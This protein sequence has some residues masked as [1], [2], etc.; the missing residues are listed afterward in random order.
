MMTAEPESRRTRVVDAVMGVLPSSLVRWAVARGAPVARVSGRTAVGSTALARALAALAQP[1]KRLWSRSGTVGLDDIADRV[2]RDPEEVRR[3]AAAGLLGDPDEPHAGRWQRAVLDRAALVDLAL[4]SG[5]DEVV[6]VRAARQGNLIWVA[7]ERVLTGRGDMTGAEAAERAGI[8]PALAE[9][10]WRALG[11]PAGELDSPAFD[12]RDV[13]AMR[14]LGSL[15]ALFSEDDLTEAASV[16]GRGMAEIST[17]L[18]ELFRRRLAAPFLEA[19]G[20]ERDVVVRLAAMRDLLVPTVAPLHEI[21]LRRHLEAAIRSEVSVAM[22]QL[23]EPGTG[24]RVVSVAFADLVGFT[25]ASEHLP[26][27][28]VRQ[29]AQALYRTVEAVVPAR[30]GR[31]IKGIGDAVM[32]TTAEPLQCA[33]ASVEIVERVDAEPLLPPVRIGIGHGPVLPGYAD[34]FGRTVNLASRLSSVAEAGQV[35]LHIDDWAIDEQRWADA[36]LQVQRRRITALKGITGDVE[37]F[38]VRARA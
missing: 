12:R 36:G 27:A 15:Q 14:T 30:G 31:I 10:V 25:A 37:A 26:A 9:A 24:R 23:L 18:V 22:E 1:P 7:L 11:L 19:G 28:E 38:A 32:F 8:S 20:T 29:L 35:L 33:L 34:Y 17:A 3:W 6:L 4:R 13:H 2:D 5:A 21:A 16:L